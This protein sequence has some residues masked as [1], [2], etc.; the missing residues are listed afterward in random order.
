MPWPHSLPWPRKMEV[1][2]RQE[3]TTVIAEDADDPDSLTVSLFVADKRRRT[4]VTLIAVAVLAYLLA[5]T[6]TIPARLVVNPGQDWKVGGTIWAGEAVFAAVHRL[7][8]TWSPLRTIGN[9]AFSADW[10]MSGADT[11][12]AGSVQIFPGQVIMK[13]VSGQAAWPLIQAM[14]P[15]F[16]FTCDSSIQIDMPLLIRGGS[17]QRIV[18]TARTGAGRCA[19]RG[20]QAADMRVPA[21]SARFQPLGRAT[22]GWVVPSGS[23]RKL[24]MAS[25]SPKGRLNVDVTS[26]GIAMLPMAQALNYDADW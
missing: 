25:L 21:L 16:P 10:R 1:P 24:L 8:W 4:G 6:A 14:A 11:D 15:R 9:L 2:M 26:A 23:G 17:D 3:Q 5:L 18:G 13:D 22:Q 20:V 19:V 7:Q 12:L